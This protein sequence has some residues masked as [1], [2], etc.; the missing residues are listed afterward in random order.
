MF[1]FGKDFEAGKKLTDVSI[2]GIS[3]TIAVIMGV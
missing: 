2:L 3:P 1:F